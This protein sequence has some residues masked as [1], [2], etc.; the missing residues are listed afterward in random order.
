M[1]IKC[2]KC[3]FE[4]Q[5][6]A[7][8]CRQ[9]GEKIN[10]DEITPESLQE[11]EDG[12]E[13]VKKGIKTTLKWVLRIVL[14]AIVGL[15]AAALIPWKLPVYTAPDESTKEFKKNEMSAQLKL[16]L[17]LAETV[18][19][20]PVKLSIDELNILFNKH[21][22]DQGENKTMSLSLEHIVF[23]KENDRIRMLGFARLFKTVPVVFR[24]DGMFSA[25][26]TVEDPLSIQVDSSAIG[27]LPLLYCNSIAASQLR[28]LFLGN[29]EI[30]RVFERTQSVTLE[31]DVLV[32]KF[33]KK[34]PPDGDAEGADGNKAPSVKRSVT[35]SEAAKNLTG[36]KRIPHSQLSPEDVALK[37]FVAGGLFNWVAYSETLPED[38]AKE[39]R[40]RKTTSEEKKSRAEMLKQDCLI[41]ILSS[42]VHS[43][44]PETASVILRLQESSSAV[45]VK[46]GLQ[47]TS[48][49]WVVV[50]KSG[51]LDE[52][53]KKKPKEED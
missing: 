34:L 48:S 29:D 26:S 30:K 43:G 16:D 28:K 2:S 14:L 6:G 37:Y 44:S 36:K 32:F 21:F 12:Q 23:S 15:L 9:C 17:A 3:G 22:L 1:M 20:I 33:G 49:G 35:L 18:P 50:S 45:I 7:I 40:K 8:F 11:K 46:L 52:G 27:H 42:E 53:G 39:F 41:E 38:E 25:G 13:K 47:K 19:S 4:N 31:G 51:F 24:A 10:M 5:M